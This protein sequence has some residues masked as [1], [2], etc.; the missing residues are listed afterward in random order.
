MLANPASV[1]GTSRCEQDQAPPRAAGSTRSTKG[2]SNAALCARHH[3]IGGLDQRARGR[4]VDRLPA[5]VA[6]GEPGERRDSR[7]ERAVRIAA[8]DLRGVVEHLD[9]PAV[10][11]IGERKQRELDDG[12]DV[13]VEARGLGVHVETAANR[14]ARRR[15][16]Q[17]DRTSSGESS[18]R[19]STHCAISTP[20]QS[21]NSALPS[22]RVWGRSTRA[23]LVGTSEATST[24]MRCVAES[25][26]PAARSV[27]MDHRDPAMRFS[28]SVPGVTCCS[29]SGARR[30]R[31][32]DPSE[33][34]CA[35]VTT[36]APPH[37]T[38]PAHRRMG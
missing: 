19:A 27:L 22:P 15:I 29:R 2:R 11:G 32:P 13:R 33:R 20:W 7:R 26:R 35:V 38:P 6:V 30:P 14:L 4:P 10:G 25:Q 1:H 28:A 21:K 3:E 8:V 17:P 31:M 36:V 12:V 5:Q 16:A 34:S 23:A 9:D 18:S 37:P 24:W